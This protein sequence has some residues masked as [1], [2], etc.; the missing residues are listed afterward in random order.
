VTSIGS[1]R[2]DKKKTPLWLR[3][4]DVDTLSWK[5]DSSCVEKREKKKEEEEEEGKKKERRKG[6][7][8]SRAPLRLVALHSPRVCLRLKTH[9][10]R[11]IRSNSVNVALRGTARPDLHASV[12]SWT[13]TIE[14]LR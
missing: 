9:L 8:G 5:I 4:G 10:F 6:E 14:R 3:S 7:E 2:T 12:S 1:R 13:F 11:G